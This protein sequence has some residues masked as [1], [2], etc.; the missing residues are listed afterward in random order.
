MKDIKIS[1]KKSQVNRFWQCQLTPL[2]EQKQFVA[3]NAVSIAEAH[4]RPDYACFRA[5]Y[6]DDLLYWI[7]YG[8]FRSSVC[9]QNEAYYRLTSSKFM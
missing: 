8:I 2:D 6:A 4:F 3:S 1:L 7:H 5:I 9:Y